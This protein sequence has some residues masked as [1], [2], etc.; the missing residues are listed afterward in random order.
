MKIAVVDDERPARSELVYLI[1]QCCPEVEIAEADSS[2]RLMELLDE[3][4]IDVCFVDIDLGGANGTTL[5]SLIKNRQPEAK[6]VFATAY[7]EYAVKAFEL[8]AVDYLLKPF[9]LERLK[10]TMSR[11]KEPGWSGAREAEPEPETEKEEVSSMSGG[12][13]L[14][15]IMVNA[16]AGFQ[17]LDATEIIYIETEKRSCRIHTKERDYIQ[18]ESMNY[19]ETRLKACRFFRIHKS[20]LVNLDY[21]AEMV[22]GYNNGYSVKMKYFEENLLPIGRTQL[23]EFRRLFGR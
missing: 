8:G 17:V 2:E 4:E 7:R 19:Y 16:G 6:I 18:N 20:F 14:H 22:P 11:L 15:K 13:A 10:K 9:D 12:M 1:R 5:A 21:V 23:K 3:M